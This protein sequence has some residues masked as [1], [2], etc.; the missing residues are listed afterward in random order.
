MATALLI[1]TRDLFLNRRLVDNDNTDNPLVGDP[2]QLLTQD[3]SIIIETLT[4]S[5]FGDWWLFC[6]GNKSIGRGTL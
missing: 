4:G 3:N 2:L 5:S 6:E 1:L